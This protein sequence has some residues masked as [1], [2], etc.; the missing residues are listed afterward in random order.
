M[1]R[2]KI[3][4]SPAMLGA[5]ERHMTWNFDFMGKCKYFFAM[6]GIILLIG[7]LALATKELN[8]GIDFESGTRVTASLERDASVEQV[9][10]VIAPLNL[11]DAKV[12]QVENPEFG[13][14]VIQIKTAELGPGGVQRLERLLEKR[15]RRRDARAL[16]ASRWARRSARP[17]RAARRSRSSLR[18][19]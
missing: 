13:K 9:R 19:C 5:G 18:C 12:Q 2:S 15:V 1:G 10:D 4:R 7:S 11:G 8:F 17:S 6:S 3:L 14:N 16:R